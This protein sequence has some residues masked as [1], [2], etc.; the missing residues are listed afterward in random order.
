MQAAVMRGGELVVDDVPEPPLSPGQLL[1]RTLACGICGSDLHALRHGEQ[2][3]S[4]AHET[5]A[6]MPD[7]PMVPEI[8]DLAHDVVMG[9]E[10][11][12]EVVAL[13][14]NVG[15]C[16]EGDVVVSM[17]VVLDAAGVH[18]VGYSNRY[19]GGYAELMVLSDLLALKVPNGLDARRAALTEPMAVGL[20]AVNKCRIQPG[21]AAVVVGC[22][23]VGLAVIAALRLHGIQH[24]VAADLSPIRRSLA[25]TMGA[26]TVV[27]PRE[28]PAVEAWRRDARTDAPVIF[29]AVGVPGM[30][31]DAMLAAPRDAHI[32]V[33]GVCMVPDTIRPM[34]GITRELSMQ[35]VL[36]YDPLE[37]ADMLRHIAE[38][39]I[40]VDPLIT[41]SV[42]IGG[43]P[44]AFADLAD[45]DAHAKIL[46]EP[47]GRP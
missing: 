44:G 29:E 41:G 2:L 33:V 47:G 23:P 35:F 30:I 20:H 11:A 36:G 26:T 10:F 14:E 19:P 38:G 8:M 45:P 34:R 3:V 43:V 32:V 16:T 18:P 9:H 22:G 40:D 24:I 1:V 37:F 5:A 31:D 27:D 39:E 46:V 4:M 25:T 42:G 28:E 21:M 12:A 15:N 17:P 6:A 7:S 13:G